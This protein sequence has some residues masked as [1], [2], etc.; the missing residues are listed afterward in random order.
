MKRHDQEQCRRRTRQKVGSEYAQPTDANQKRQS[1]DDPP[2]K[3]REF[4]RSISTYRHTEAHA[5]A[6]HNPYAQMKGIQ[7]SLEEATLAAGRNRYIVDGLPLKTYDCS[8]ITDGYAALIL[9][10]EEGLQK[11]GVSKADTVEL[12]GYGQATDPVKKEGRDI[13]RPAG[14]LKAMQE[15]WFKSSDWIV[16]L[17]DLTVLKDF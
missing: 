14:A 5:N 3:G 10:T 16:S 13:L 15:F 11:L 7:V 1:A 17:P 8:Q 2:G 6:Q 4:A 9:A 12:A